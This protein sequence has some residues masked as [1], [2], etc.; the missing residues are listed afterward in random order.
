MGPIV[1]V[2]DEVAERLEDTDLVEAVVMPDAVDEPDIELGPA[3]G[4]FLLLVETPRHG[5]GAL[6]G[7]ITGSSYIKDRAQGEPPELIVRDR[8]GQPHPFAAPSVD[9][10]A[11]QNHLGLAYFGVPGDRRPLLPPAV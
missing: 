5:F 4:V 2:P 8:D 1:R 6:V 11:I 3:G 9:D 7:V 10:A